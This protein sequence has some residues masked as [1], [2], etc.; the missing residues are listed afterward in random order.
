MEIKYRRKDLVKTMRRL[1]AVYGKLVEQL[2]KERVSSFSLVLRLMLFC[3][4]LETSAL[5]KK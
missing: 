2:G 5:K 1:D 4:K 3:L